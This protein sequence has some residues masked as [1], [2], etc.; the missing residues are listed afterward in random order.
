MPST[1]G[2]PRLMNCN[3]KEMNSWHSWSPNSRWIVFSSKNRGPYTQLYLTHIDENGMDS[4]PVLLENLCFENRAANIPEFYPF[5]SSHFK[6]IKDNFSKTPQYF[7]R[8]ALDAMS[9]KYYIRAMDDLNNAIKIDSNYMESYFN[10]MMLNIVLKQS[11]SNNDITYKKKVLDIAQDSLRRKPWDENYLSLKITLLSNMGRTEEA[12]EEAKLA[13]QKYPDSFKFHELLSSIY[14]K[15]NQSEKAIQC[16]KVMMKINPREKLRLNNLIADTYVNI[17]QNNEALQM[18]NQLVKERPN[19]YD[20]LFSRA[21]IL[22]KMKNFEMAKKDIDFLV[23]KDSSIYKYNRLL[24]Q[25]YLNQGNKRLNYFQIKNNL[26]L[27]HDMYDKNN[28]DVEVIFELAS[29]YLSLGDLKNS[30]NWYNIILSY[31]PDNYEA[32]KQKAMIKL[33]M[34]LWN[35]AI[36]IYDQLESNYPPEEEFYNNK[37]IAYIQ[38]GNYSK[39]LEYFNKTIELN[40]NNKDALFN[41]DKLK[42]EMSGLR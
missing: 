22:L 23:S 17:N 8:S 26:Q 3:M 4:P 10:R 38:N 6:K 25:Y 29:L 9:N 42:S 20:L 28:E 24:A 37:A 18:V 36:V 34:Q 21:Q 2:T 15:K 12:F 35:D 32:L 41:R 33:K 19:D 13:I 11:N 16:Y 39:A 1:G 14:R 30:E 31:F 40:P 27:L 7:N 5:D